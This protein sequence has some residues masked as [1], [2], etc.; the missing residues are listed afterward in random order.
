MTNH[1]PL[2]FVQQKI[3]ELRN[4]LFVPLSDSLLKLSVCI[5]NVIKVD[6]L[7]QI[8]F[9]IP[10]PVQDIREFDNAFASKLDFFKKGKNFYL[11]ILGKAFIITD[12]EEINN[13]QIMPEARERALRQEIVLIK[14]KIT[15]ADYFEQKPEKVVHHSVFKGAIGFLQRWIFR[16]RRGYDLS[17]YKKIP[18]KQ[19]IFPH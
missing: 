8:W 5:V 2:S 14:V 7:G 16:L 6:E 9:A 13:I 4:A 3:V 1:L 11:K 12:P 17:L 15:N 10:F 19:S 18:V